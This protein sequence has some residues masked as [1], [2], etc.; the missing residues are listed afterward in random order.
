MSRRN[1]PRYLA[2]GL[3]AAATSPAT[4]QSPNPWRGE[5]VEVAPAPRPVAVSPFS[6]KADPPPPLRVEVARGL[7]QLGAQLEVPTW[8]P[9]AAEPPPA[10]WSTADQIEALSTLLG[11]VANA[12]DP[13]LG[14]VVRVQ[15]YEHGITLPSPR[16]LQH[17]PQYVPADPA[18]PLQRELATQAPPLPGVAPARAVGSAPLGTWHRTVGVMTYAVV[19]KDTHLTITAKMTV[20]MGTGLTATKKTV[21]QGVV[22]TC[23]YHM[24]RD[25]SN[26][27][28]LV[29]GVDAVCDGTPEAAEGNE[30]PKMITKLQKAMTDKPFAVS[31]RVYDGALVIGNVRLPACEDKDLS[32][33]LESVGGWYQPVSQFARPVPPTTPVVPASGITPKARGANSFAP[34]PN[35][36]IQQLLEQTEDLRQIGPDWRD[37]WF[38]Q[39]PSHLTPERI[40][41]AIF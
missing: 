9:P 30:L 26:L 33:P 35:V 14:M 7:V 8:T 37:F 28:G 22:L 27:V 4:A 10:Q 19:V 1:I 31:F 2:A 39:T 16:Y 18:F 20:E 29:T 38:H 21:T 34:D 11:S 40:H 15:R 25:G 24:T 41:G 5:P 36:R 3:L 12:L 32:G 13:V 23:D 6:D 17:Y